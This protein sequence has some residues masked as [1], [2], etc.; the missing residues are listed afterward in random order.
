MTS[1]DPDLAMTDDEAN[2]LRFSVL[3][4]A[5]LGG[6]AAEVGVYKGHS[7]S[8]IR[9]N[10]PEDV[11]LFLFDTFEGIPDLITE[12]DVDAFG[13]SLR[14]SDWVAPGM[15]AASEYD[16]RDR[17]ADSPNVII[18]RGLFPASAEGIITNESFA[19]VHLDVDL[20]Q[21]TVE[22]LQFFCFRMLPDGLIL[23]H[24]YDCNPGIKAA[25]ERFIGLSKSFKLS[26]IHG[27]NG[28][29]LLWHKT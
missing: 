5:M 26:V 23:V 4:C 27:H 25:C 29:A 1:Y 13:R 22:V 21:P 18:T 12:E 14:E 9:N 6:C 28:Q 11:P 24:D 19:F 20:Y 2:V 8:I 17:F 3:K 16:V 7:A 15:Y 10:L